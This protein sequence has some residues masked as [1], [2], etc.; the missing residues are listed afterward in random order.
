M[1]TFTDNSARDYEHECARLDEPAPVLPYTAVD[2]ATFRALME[3][4]DEPFP[5]VEVPF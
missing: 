4:Q 3:Q 2:E 5:P 1:W